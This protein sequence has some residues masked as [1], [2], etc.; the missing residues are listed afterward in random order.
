MKKYNN[1]EDLFKSEL[2]QFETDPG[3]GAWN[4]IQSKIVAQQAVVTTSSVAGTWSITKI[5]VVSSI[6]SVSAG[7]GIGYLY[8]GNEVKKASKIS[9][10]ESPETVQPVV[11]TTSEN[12]ESVTY[13]N[14]SSE[15]SSIIITE[16]KNSTPTRIKVKVKENEGASSIVNSWLTPSDKK[17][18]LLSTKNNTNDNVT[19]TE[20]SEVKTPNKNIDKVQIEVKEELLDQSAPIA[21]IFADKSAGVAPLRV[22]FSNYGRAS[23]YEWN[24]GDGTTSTEENPE[25]IFEKAG[26]YTINLTLKN[27]DGK[28]STDQITIVVKQESSL[29][30]SIKPNVISPNGDGINDHL[31]GKEMKIEANNID[32]FQVII[33]D[34]QGT[35]LFQSSDINFIWDG[36]DLSG[37]KLPKGRYIYQIKANGADGSEFKETVHLTI[38]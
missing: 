18:K 21:G 14:Q 8:K 6:I 17:D 16:N 1:I 5:I 32:E 35:L 12:D 30:I 25:H 24:F 33:F 27:S 36:T 29:V 20:K 37:K 31:S 9:K 15:E 23:N 28:K 7:I 11:E 38:Q 22:N 34:L 2:G 19:N 4:A 10:V 3:A 13:E 26:T